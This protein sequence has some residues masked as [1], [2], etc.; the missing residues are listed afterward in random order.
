ML[1][2]SVLLALVLGS[3]LLVQGRSWWAFVLGGASIVAGWGLDRGELDPAVLTVLAVGGALA[4][5]TG[6]PALRRV[7]VTGPSMRLVAPLLPRM[8]ETERV[9]LEA[10]TVWWDGEL[11]SGRPDWDRLARFEPVPLTDEEQR[12]LDEEVETICRMTDNER[13]DELGDLPPEVW[14]YL[15]SKRFMGLI[16]PREYGGLDFSGTIH[17]GNR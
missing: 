16:I 11:F 17:A 2:P 1:L 13:V 10:G 7:L 5:I 3:V 6:I 15:K 8:S 12:F 14:S 4:A 9:A